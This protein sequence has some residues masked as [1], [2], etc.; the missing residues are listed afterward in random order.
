MTF[1][2]HL[3]FSGDA[4]NLAQTISQKRLCM[5]EVPIEN[6]MKPRVK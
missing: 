1:E 2:Y 4:E 5:D 6:T 3:A